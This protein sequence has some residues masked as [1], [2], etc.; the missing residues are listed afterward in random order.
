[1]SSINH[2]AKWTTAFL[3]HNVVFIV[4]GCGILGSKGEIMVKDG[5]GEPIL[6]ISKKVMDHNFKI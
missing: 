5:E 2:Q 4:D 3:S 1:V 6:F